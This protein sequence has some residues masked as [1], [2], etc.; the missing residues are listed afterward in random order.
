VLGAFL[1]PKPVGM[2]KFEV[3]GKYAKATF[4]EGGALA[5]YDQDTTE[6]NFNYVIK[7][8]NARIMF[9]LINTNFS[10]VKTDGLRVG[11]GL[12]LQM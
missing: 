6:F 12:Q 1:F 8:F 4:R 3:L 2:G 9:F 10:A 7:E 5:D 11:V